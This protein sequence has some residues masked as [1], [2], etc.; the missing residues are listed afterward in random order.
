[1][2]LRGPSDLALRI[3]HHDVSVASGRDGAFPRIQPENLRCCS[4][5][6]LN[7]SVDINPPGPHASVPKQAHPLLD[8]GCSVG[9]FR[10]AVLSELLLLLHA[11]WT[12][13]SRHQGQVVL[14]QA[15]P[16][17]FHVCLRST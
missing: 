16:E 11:E 9:D 10:E 8:S 12:V 17:L 3:K 15:G 13:V 1:M 7:V 5:G 2:G 14:L 6:D 4:A